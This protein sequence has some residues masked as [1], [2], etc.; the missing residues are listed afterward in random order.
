M[1]SLNPVSNSRQQ[2]GLGVSPAPFPNDTAFSELLTESMLETPSNPLDMEN[3]FSSAAAPLSPVSVAQA[4]QPATAIWMWLLEQILE[5]AAQPTTAQPAAIAD[6]PVETTAADSMVKTATGIIPS[7]TTSAPPSATAGV[8]AKAT[9]VSPLNAIIENASNR[10]GV[11][12]ALIR[13]VI[14]QESGGRTDAVSAAGAAGLMQLM[15]GTAQALGV[16]DVFNPSENVL[17]GTR[18]LAQLLQRFDGNVPLAL[19][20]YNAGPKAVEEYHGIPPYSET[21]RYVTRV[22]QLAN[23]YSDA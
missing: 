9:E 13:A 2:S 7:A 8:R 12:A 19:A 18:Y 1:T 10:Y 22:L 16:Q 23:Q 4:A 15:P 21:Q 17:A 3:S 11:P 20:A 14:E 6:T 5:E